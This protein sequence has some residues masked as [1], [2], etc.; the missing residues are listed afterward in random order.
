M[1][2]V[3]QRPAGPHVQTVSGLLPVHHTSSLQGIFPKGHATCTSSLTLP[4]SLRFPDTS[5]SIPCP[6]DELMT[7]AYELCIVCN[8]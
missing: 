8:L 5:V 4:S 6:I 3:E 1:A 7:S 2:A